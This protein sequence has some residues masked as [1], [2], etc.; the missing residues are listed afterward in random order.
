MQN[1]NTL[2]QILLII[3][4]INTIIISVGLVKI[5]NIVSEQPHDITVEVIEIQENPDAASEDSSSDD[6]KLDNNSYTS[7]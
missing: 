4:I 7:I 1:N 2:I 3:S 6:L 5:Y